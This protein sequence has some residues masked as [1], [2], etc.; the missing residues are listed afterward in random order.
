MCVL[1]VGDKDLSVLNDGMKGK[2]LNFT[3]ADIK[4]IIVPSKQRELLLAQIKNMVNY[5]DKDKEILMSKI[6]TTELIFSDI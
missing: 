2:L 5:P 4:Y 1:T 6:L 3:V